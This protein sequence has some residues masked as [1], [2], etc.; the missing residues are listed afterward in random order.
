MIFDIAIFI[1]VLGELV[2][3]HEMGHFLAAKAC[4]IYCERF[5]LGMPP[6][7]FGFRYGETDYCLGLLPIGGYV[8]MAGQEDVPMTDEERKEQYGSVPPERWFS[9]KPV[10]QRVIVIAAGPLMNVVLAVLLYGIVAAVGADVPEAKV[11]SRIGR[12]L[13]DSPAAEARLFEI[14]GPEQEADAVGEPDALGWKTGDRIVRINGNPVKSFSDIA[15]DSV[16]SNSG[17]LRVILER[18]MPDGQIKTYLCDAQPRLREGDDHPTLGVERFQTAL[19]GRV[20]DGMPAAKAGLRPDDV[21]QRVNGE[22]VDAGTFSDLVNAN[23]D[24]PPSTLEVQRGA[25]TLTVPLAPATVG[26]IEGVF[27]SPPINALIAFSPDTPLRVEFENEE[28]LERTTLQAGDVLKT[29]DG[30]PANVVLLEALEEKGASAPLAVDVERTAGLFRNRKETLN[31]QLSLD[32]IRQALIPQDLTAKPTIAELSQEAEKETGLLRK[33][34]IEEVNG[35]PATIAL[36]REAEK[37]P[38][39]SVQLTV[40]TPA[41]GYGV[42]REEATRT[43][44]LPVATLGQVGIVW[45]P[46]TVFHRAEPG[47]IVPEAFRLSWQALDRTLKTL[48]ML[49]TGGLKINDIGGPVMIFQITADAARIGYSWLLETTAFI[50]INLAIFNLLPLP[51]LD[52]GHLVFLTIEGVRRKPVSTRVTEWV[53]QAGLVFII[54]LMLFVTYNDVKRWF[55]DAFMP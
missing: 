45:K 39:T 2:F 11:D 51:V 24:G 4:G 27:F 23:P 8:K 34:V 12:V 18:K 25:E 35:Q 17:T 28:F 52:G 22:W 7:L 46:K 26:Q 48:V 9:N 19:V 54:A 42:L 6:R 29:F 20:L 41:V 14:K 47:Q 30:Q 38:G 44:E 3:F 53:Q 5:S 32:D 49:V 55:L 37:H 43:V 40:R 1:L 21:I 36:L 50:S 10:W 31:L 16:L 13:P 33:D 15:I